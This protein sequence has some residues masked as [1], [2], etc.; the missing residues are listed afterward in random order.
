MYI[1]DKKYP[2]AKKSLKIDF[3]DLFGEIPIF[4]L[5][6]QLIFIFMK[7]V[8]TAERTTVFPAVA[9]F[10]FFPAVKGSL[11]QIRNVI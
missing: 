11:A 8:R 6:Q 10:S 7:L 5:F 1:F 4:S 2:P 9:I 3:K